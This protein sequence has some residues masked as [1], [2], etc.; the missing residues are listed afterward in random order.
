MKTT[1]TSFRLLIS[2]IICIVLAASFELGLVAA[3]ILFGLSVL[4]ASGLPKG[5]LMAGTTLCGE[6]TKGVEPDCD[7]PLVG[8]ADD[9]L[10]LFNEADLESVVRNIVN[11]QIIEGFT[12]AS[13]KKAFCFQGKNN[14]VEPRAALVEQ[15]YSEVYDHEVI[16]KGFNIG[17]D[18]KDQYERLAKGRVLAIVLNNFRGEDGIAAFELYGIAVGL[19]AR[20]LER[21]GADTETQGAYNIVLRTPDE[22]KEPNLPN[23]IFL[24]DFATTKALVDALL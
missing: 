11:K 2:A 21:I 16:F 9:A 24:N 13:G 17:P 8:G 20:E 19:K 14:S 6:I 4:A 1:L 23:T 7:F 5:V 15:R 12:L 18:E 10:I 3:G 22:V